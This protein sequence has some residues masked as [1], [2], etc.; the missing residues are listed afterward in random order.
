MKDKV[1]TKEQLVDELKEMR[2]RMARLEVLESRHKRIEEA[3][4]ESE[5][6]FETLFKQAGTT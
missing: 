1:R 6:R 5:G 4:R 3:L 2:Q